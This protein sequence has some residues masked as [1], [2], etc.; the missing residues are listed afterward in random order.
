M[1]SFDQ[2]Q[3][4]FCNIENF[5]FSFS[6]LLMQMGKNHVLSRFYITDILLYMLSHLNRKKINTFNWIHIAS[7]WMIVNSQYWSHR[8]N[9]S[10]KSNQHS[11]FKPVKKTQHISWH[12]GC[13][14]KNCIQYLSHFISLGKKLATI[15]KEGLIPPFIKLVFKFYNNF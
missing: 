2:Q 1:C 10:T 6:S 13:F 5:L 7:P 8:T 12:K 4:S 14:S 9:H 11:L 3:N 15:F